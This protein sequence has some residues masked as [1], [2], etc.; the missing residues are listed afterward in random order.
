MSTDFHF[1][2][3]NDVWYSIDSSSG[4]V[5]RICSAR[6]RYGT[7]QWVLDA[8]PANKDCLVGYAGGWAPDV[9]VYP[10]DEALPDTFATL[11]VHLFEAEKKYE[12]A[13]KA[14]AKSNSK[15]FESGIW[16]GGFLF[17]ILGIIVG[18][19]ATSHSE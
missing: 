3:K 16:L 9:T 13:T 14:A 15:A 10:L 6:S 19:A 5:E 8:A 12:E 7:P 1:V 4:H 11:S 18:V 2:R 17:G